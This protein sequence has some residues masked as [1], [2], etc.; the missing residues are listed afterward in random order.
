[1]SLPKTRQQAIDKFCR[2]CSPKGGNRACCECPL[3]R[4]GPWK[5]Q[6]RQGSAGKPIKV[7]K[8]KTQKPRV[9]KRIRRRYCQS[10]G[11]QTDYRELLEIKICREC[12]MTGRIAIL[13]KKNG[14]EKQS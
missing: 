5:G 4:W 10:C 1:M 9:D 6:N 8:I 2:E 14:K 13:Q 12:L 3:F 11:Q 7:P